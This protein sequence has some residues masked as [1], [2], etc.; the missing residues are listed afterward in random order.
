MP[1][2]STSQI[3]GN[4]ECFEPQYSNTYSRQT[5]AGVFV[6]ANKHLVNDMIVLGKWSPKVKQSIIENFGSAQQLDIPKELKD[7]YKTVWEISQ[8]VIINMAAD[9]G[10][11]I[12]QSMSLN[13]FVEDPTYKKISS[14]HWYAFKAGLKTGIY[15]LR[16]RPK[17]RAQQFTVEVGSKPDEQAMAEAAASQQDNT[18]IC[19]SCSG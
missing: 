12:C 7:I 16:T 4:T 19:E 14:M 8:R 13:L 5:L 17:A 18:H 15:Y 3:L 9:R 10:Q 11:F 6:I 1:T 2:A